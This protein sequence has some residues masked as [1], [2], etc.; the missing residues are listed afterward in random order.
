M[1]SWQNLTHLFDTNAV[2]EEMQKKY[3]DTLLQININGRPHYA[4]YRGFDG[5]YHVFEDHLKTP[6][7]I[8]HETDIEVVIVFPKKGLYNTS[9]GMVMFTRK[10]HRQYRKGISEDSCTILPV[11]RTLFGPSTN[12]LWTYI[13]EIMS[14]SYPKTVREALDSLKN[15][16]S[17]ALNR[18]FGISLPVCNDTEKYPV[19]YYQNIVGYIK[20]NTIH[21]AN[22]AFHQ[23]FI[24]ASLD[25]T[26]FEVKY[27]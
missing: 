25:T 23:E 8:H 9:R 26:G 4:T 24:D 13:H 20:D 27:L 14:S 11:L 17:V 5:D 3:R 19:Y 18:Q 6:L 16:G 2:I 12:N 1:K 22:S 15:F 21:I 10:P 7:K